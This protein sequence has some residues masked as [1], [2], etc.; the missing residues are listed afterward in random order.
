MRFVAPVRAELPFRT[1]FN[2]LGPLTNPAGARRQLVGVFG[3]AYVRPVAEA[4][5]DLGA[6][7]A[8]VVHGTDGMDEITVTDKTIVAEVSGGELAE[9]EISPE[10]FGLPLHAPDGLLGGD[11][12]LNARILRDILTGEEQGATRDIVLLNAGAAI[13][14]SGK[15]KTI[16]Q[17]VRLAHDSIANGAAAGALEEFIKTTR[18]L[19]GTV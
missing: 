18:R 6:E 10:D 12:H 1:I 7:K 3:G 17:G 13:H 8:L 15:A 2:L 9:Y 19:S 14:V 11:A 16:E 5:R 4:L